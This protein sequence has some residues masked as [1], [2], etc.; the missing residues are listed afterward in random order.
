LLN[1]WQAG[2]FDG[3]QCLIYTITG[4]YFLREFESSRMNIRYI[5]NLI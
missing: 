1:P 5:I 4:K 2:V 3:D